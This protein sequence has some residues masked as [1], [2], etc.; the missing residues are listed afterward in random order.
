MAKKKI[1]TLKQQLKECEQIKQEYLA[2]W[3][4]AKADLINYKNQETE[5]LE[6]L[7]QYVGDSFII[8]MLL[9]LDNFE[10]AEQNLP[11]KLKQDNNVK[12]LI[13]IKKQLSSFMQSRGLEQIKS[14]GTKFN[15][16]FHEAIEEVQV[17]NKES[18]TIVEEIKKGYKLNG[19]VIRP[20]KVKICQ[21]Y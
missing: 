20:A 18:G 10:I 16:E 14:L 15:P 12:G 11:K 13:Q 8:E 4:R 6:K 3:Q 19:R 17:S 2:G 5:R 7:L 1:K 21:K 9:I